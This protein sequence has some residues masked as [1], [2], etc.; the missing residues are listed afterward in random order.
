[1]HGTEVRVARI[2]NTYGPRMLENDGRVISNFIVQAL[3]GNSLTIYGDGQQT[4]SFCYI[5]DMTE[6]LM[7]LMEHD[8]TG[9]INLGNPDEISV[10]Q[11]ARK[12]CSLIN[13]KLEVENKG[14]PEDDPLQRQP[15]ITKAR[16]ELK[17]E[18]SVS[19]E[20]GLLETINDFRRR[21]ESTLGSTR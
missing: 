4:R 15:V 8:Q 6:G 7:R 14:K 2:F 19:L 20:Q 13:K 10:H 18:P 1:M 16:K 17:W 5:N 21:R 3:S 9:P 12:I 11:L